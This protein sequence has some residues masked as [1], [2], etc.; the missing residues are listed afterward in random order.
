MENSKKIIKLLETIQNKQRE[1]VKLN[2]ELEKLTVEL[3]N[4]AHKK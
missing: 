2:E 1:I 3:E 4:Y